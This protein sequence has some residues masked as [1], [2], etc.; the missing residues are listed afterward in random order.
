MP[1][2]EY[3]IRYVDGLWQIRCAGHLVGAKQHKMDS[4]QFA[5]ALVRAGTDRG[6]QSKILIAD[7]KG[8]TFE[9]PVAGPA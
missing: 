6:E 9:F 3:V 4:L 8:T 2:L 5:D 1:T 7:I